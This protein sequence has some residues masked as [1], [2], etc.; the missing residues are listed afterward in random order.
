M[1]DKY[2][3]EISALQ[4]RAEV[5]RKDDREHYKKIIDDLKD[6][7]RDPRDYDRPATQGSMLVSKDPVVIPYPFNPV[8]GAQP[9][10]FAPASYPPQHKQH[11][12]GQGRFDDG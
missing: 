1:K 6:E 5:M 12:I 2:E 11:K 10:T 8:Y 7:L 3:Y 9:G 4:Q